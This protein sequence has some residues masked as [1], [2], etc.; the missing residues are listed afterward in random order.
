MRFSFTY[1]SEGK[2]ETFSFNDDDRLQ[3]IDHNVSALA[4]DLNILGD[5]IM[6]SLDDVL[7]DVTAE[8]T[9]IDSLVVLLNGI[10]QQL[11]DA[12]SGTVI[13]PA[14]QAK[15]DAIFTQAEANKTKL[16]DAVTANTP[17]ANP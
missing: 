13:P 7:N 12:L 8:S 11:A 3:R 5:R 6:A 10:K 9:V 14:V 17:A 16:S 4:R 2:L 1:N 15:I